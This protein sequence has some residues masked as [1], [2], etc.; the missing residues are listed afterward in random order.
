MSFS[1]LS[2]VVFAWNSVWIISLAIVW[3][4][5]RHGTP[6]N[7]N[8]WTPI[9]SVSQQEIIWQFD[10]NFWVEDL[11][12]YITGHYTTIQCDGIYGPA[13]TKLTGVFLKAWNTSPILMQW[14]IGNVFIASGLA[15]YVNILTPITYIYK[16]TDP[17]NVWRLNQYGDKPRLK[18][19]IP[20]YSPPGN[21][22]GT[23]VFSLYMY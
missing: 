4:G 17:S 5:I 1:L 2:Y 16:P 6:N 8:L 11:Q 20:A 15:D 10:D 18:I 22:S 23:I 12:G 19:I 3:V 14:S 7:V 13:G 9:T 21:Y